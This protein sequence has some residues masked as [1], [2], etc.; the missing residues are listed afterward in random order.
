M[1][2]EVTPISSGHLITALLGPLLCE[3]DRMRI[4]FLLEV[5]LAEGLGKNQSKQ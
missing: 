2:A 3:M 4:A 1:R 5:W